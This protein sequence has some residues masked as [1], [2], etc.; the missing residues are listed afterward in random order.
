MPAPTLAE[1]SRPAVLEVDGTSFA[2]VGF[3]AIGETPQA[4]PGEL[5]ALSVRMPPRTGTV[6]NQGDLDHMAGW[7]AAPRGRRTW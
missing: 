4:F 5:G 6:I 2:F 3:N 1:A 7:S